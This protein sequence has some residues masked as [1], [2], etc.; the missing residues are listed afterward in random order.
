MIVK[1]R[2]VRGVENLVLIA[3]MINI[4]VIIVV[5]IR[6]GAP[7]INWIRILKCLKKGRDYI[8]DFT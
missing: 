1:S 5:N 4:K 7:G 8:S 2:R 6:R 3:V